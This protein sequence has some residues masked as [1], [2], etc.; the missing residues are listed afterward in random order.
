MCIYENVGIINKIQ[1]RPSIWQH[2]SGL[3]KKNSVSGYALLV[4]NVRRRLNCPPL[5]EGN[6][7]SADHV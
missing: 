4:F 7:N 5:L 3:P 2:L 6:T 1:N